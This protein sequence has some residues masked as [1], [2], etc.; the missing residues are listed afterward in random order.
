M[1]WYPATRWTIQEGLLHTIHWKGTTGSKQVSQGS[2]HWTRLKKNIADHCLCVSTLCLPA[3]SQ[4]S[5]AIPHP[6]RICTLRVIN[7]WSW[8]WPVL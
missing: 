8:E 1:F 3:C 6:L 2:Q 4:T 7:E 5:Q